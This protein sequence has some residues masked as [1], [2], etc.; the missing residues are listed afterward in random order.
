MSQAAGDWDAR[1][2]QDGFVEFR[3]ARKLW[4]PLVLVAFGAI[5]ALMIAVDGPSFAGI[6]CV[7]VFGVFLAMDVATRLRGPVALRVQTDGIVVTG[8]F[9]TFVPWSAAFGA[10]VVPKHGNVPELIRVLVIADWYDEWRRSGPALQ[11]WLVALGRI[12]DSLPSIHVPPLRD[13]QVAVVDWFADVMIERRAHLPL[14]EQ[15]LVGPGDGDSPVWRGDSFEAVALEK[16]GLSDGTTQ[17]LRDW[18]GRCAAVAA[19]A[20][21]DGDVEATPEWPGLVAEGR[22]LAVHVGHELVG[23]HTVRWFEDPPS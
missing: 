14:P 9:S 13:D 23:R 18:D 16:L 20:G 21:E 7:V 12:F 5:G 19:R 4:V 8:L 1:L 17:S 3:R 15:L 11:R 2:A 22:S 10:M 6:L